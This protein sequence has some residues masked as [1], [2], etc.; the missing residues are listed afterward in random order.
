[1][2]SQ[3]CPEL[4][5]GSQ[6]FIQTHQPVTFMNIGCPGRGH[7]PRLHD[8]LQLKQFQK[9]LRIENCLSAAYAIVRGITSSCLKRESREQIITSTQTSK[10]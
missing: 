10:L 8:F 9:E 6:V 1:M 2:T 4:G 5:Q 7:D 3:N